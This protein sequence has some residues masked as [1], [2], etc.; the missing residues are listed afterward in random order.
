M[1]G[2]TLTGCTDKA[3][4]SVAVSSSNMDDSE[5]D[6]RVGLM[7]KNFIPS[8]WEIMAQFSGSR[9]TTAF[10]FNRTFNESDLF[11][12][13]TTASATAIST[14]TTTTTVPDTNTTVSPLVNDT[15]CSPNSTFMLALPWIR[16]TI[17]LLM[18]L[19]NSLSLLALWH[20]KR[21]QTAIHR[22]I[23]SLAVAELLMGVWSVSYTH[24]RAHET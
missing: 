7:S 21:M 1:S 4:L 19:E 20:V 13:A 23:S 10:L 12:N 15:E 24:L 14:T 17:G 22:F 9:D 11:T 5:A 16:I 6:D 3:P 2:C 8:M 18:V